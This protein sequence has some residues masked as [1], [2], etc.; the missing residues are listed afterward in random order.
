M[1]SQLLYSVKDTFSTYLSDGSRYK[2]P[3]YQRGYKWEAKDINRLLDDVDTFSINNLDV[4]YCLQNI[5]LVK[6]NNQDDKVF[7]VVDGQQRLT[8]LAILLA[9]LGHKKLVSGKLEYS[10][11]SDTE[12]FLKNY[13]FS[14]DFPDNLADYS[15]SN[16][17]ISNQWNLFLENSSQKS[18][19]C[20]YNHQDIFYIFQAHLIIKHW[21]DNHLDRREIMEKKILN[22]VKLIINLPKIDD[23]QKLFVNL[24]GKRVAL[25]GADLVRAMIITRSSKQHIGEGDDSVKYNVLLNEYRARVGMELDT[26][27]NWWSDTEKQTYFGFLRIGLKL[28]NDSAVTFDWNKHPINNLYGLYALVSNDKVLSLE[29]YEQQVNNSDFIQKLFDFQRMLQYWYTDRE[30]YHLIMFCCRHAKM[31]FDSLYDNWKDCNRKEFI[32][33]LKAKIAEIPAVKEILEDRTID[34]WY[35]QKLVTVSVLVDII[36]LLSIKGS[37]EMLPAKY[38]TASDEDLEHIFPQTPIADRI[39]DSN[40]QTQILKEY[41]ELINN[42][43]EVKTEKIHIEDDEINWDNEEWRRAIKE[44]INTILLRVIPINS[45]GNMCVLDKNVNRGYGND[46][47]LEKRIDIMTKSRQGIFIRPHVYDAFNKSFLRREGSTI[48]VE[49]MKSWGKKDIDERKNYITKQVK[50]YI[51]DEQ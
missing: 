26:I 32:L 10:V 45:I 42:H 5:T 35:D 38:F 15:L 51:E 50:K 49:R 29:F 28:Q 23:E 9:Y 33:I 37:K 25:D 11:R 22:H 46:F 4:F 7:N 44:K 8:T 20:D 18:T 1:K 21:F 2:I 16:N 39:K 24:N 41:I 48:S 31:S 47:Y 27:N 36:N 30:L 34:D 17:D 3:V 13:I 40:K 6:N 43:I 14:D 19:D 12:Y